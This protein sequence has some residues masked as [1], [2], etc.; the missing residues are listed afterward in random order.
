MLITVYVPTKNRQA[1]LAA[2]VESVLGQ[3]HREL[4]LIVVDDGSTDGSHG[5]LAELARRD[6]RVRFIRHEESLGG[7]SA[8]NAAIRAANGHF[9]TGLD[10]DDSFAPDR[11]ASFLSGW[12]Q[13]QARG[14]TPS[15]L[16]SQLTEMHHGQPVGVTSKPEQARYEDM[17]ASNVVGNQVFA[18]KQHYLDA[19]LFRE[20]LP[21]WQDLEFF[22]RLLKHCGPGRLLDRASYN[23]DNTPRTD[24]VSMK[25]EEKM[26]K[27]F[28]IVNAAHSDGQGRRTQQLYLQLFA[29]LYGIRPGLGDYRR[30]LALGLWPAGLVQMAKASVRR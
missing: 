9:V 26:R 23:F 7:P 5:Y 13:L 3:S 15:C 18:P 11:L 4:E 29:R 22:M 2:A 28:E 25:S 8:R 20:D 30:F 24:R 17:F 27:A 16:Y 12:Q 6:A 14:E 21:A 19:G 10:D 1:L